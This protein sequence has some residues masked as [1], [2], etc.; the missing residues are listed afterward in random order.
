MERFKADEEKGLQRPELD[1][2]PLEGADHLI[3]YLFSCGP[4]SGGEALTFQEIRAWMDLTGRILTAWEAETLRVI[5]A[6]YASEAFSA[7]D[8][9]RQPPYRATPFAREAP[10]RED[11]SD[12]LK[13]A[14]ELLERQDKGRRD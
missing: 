6:A 13:A 7:S 10:S 9:D 4:T 5:S 8:V 1:F 2:P 12:R 14:F 3:D 11:V